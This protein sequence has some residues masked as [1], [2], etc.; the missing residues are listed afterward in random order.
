MFWS[1]GG[2]GKESSFNLTDASN[3]ACQ[4][5]I[6]AYSRRQAMDWSLVLA[7][8]G[9][10]ATIEPAAVPGQYE[11][12]V[13]AAD[14]DFARG[15]IRQYRREMQVRG[16]PWTPESSHAVFDWSSLAWAVGVVLFFLTAGRAGLVAA[17][18]LDSAQVAQ[19]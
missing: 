6:V 4:A 11:L 10:E 13:P 8:Q 19:G 15:T 7:S 9:V 16:R 14:E 3:P 18:I 5:R 12:V 17:G 2:R 1:G